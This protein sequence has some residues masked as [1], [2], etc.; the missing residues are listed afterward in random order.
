MIKALTSAKMASAVLNRAVSYKFCMFG[1]APLDPR[2]HITM[3]HNHHN[4]YLDIYEYG[5]YPDWVHIHSVPARTYEHLVVDH[6]VTALNQ[7]LVRHL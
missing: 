1:W 4:M 3:N 7:R 5:Q 2:K 6:L